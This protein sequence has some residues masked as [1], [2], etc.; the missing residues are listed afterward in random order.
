RDVADGDG[1][2][3]CREEGERAG[4]RHWRRALRE[5]RGYERV[6]S[7]PDGIRIPDVSP[8]LTSRNTRTSKR[9][10]ELA[11]PRRTAARAGQPAPKTDRPRPRPGTPTATAA[12]PQMPGCR[13]SRAS[14]GP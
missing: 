2:P 10:G 8:Q 3:G 6:L 13:P 7:A 14:S 11:W 9:I 4:D 5:P 1:H 12:A